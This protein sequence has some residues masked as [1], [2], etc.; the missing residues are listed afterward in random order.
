MIP[1]RSGSPREDSPEIEH[2]VFPFLF[3]LAPILSSHGDNPSPALLLNPPH[4]D[5]RPADLALPR[6]QL[7]LFA[8]GQPLPNELDGPVD[9]DVL[10][11]LVLGLLQ[12]RLHLHPACHYL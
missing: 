9:A 8:L 11:A 4:D 7:H 2:I 12:H 5:A 6:Q 1:G 10:H 3:P